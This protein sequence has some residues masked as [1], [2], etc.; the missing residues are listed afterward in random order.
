MG[1]LKVFTISRLRQNDV[2]KNFST[3]SGARVH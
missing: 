2:K 3:F 1:A